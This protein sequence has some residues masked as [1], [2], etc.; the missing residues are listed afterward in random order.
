[1]IGAR[2]GLQLLTIAAIGG[3]GV[4]S[5]R[6]LSCAFRELTDAARAIIGRLDVIELGAL[7]TKSNG[8]DPH[9]AAPSPVKLE[10][11]N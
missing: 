7:E 1:V 10:R 8:A 2:F 9:I 11:R 3:L 6:R 5:D 4:W